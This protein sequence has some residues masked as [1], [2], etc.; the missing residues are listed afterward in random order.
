MKN[1]KI[2]GKIFFWILRIASL[3]IL[4]AALCIRVKQFLTR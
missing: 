2:T 1:R 3:I 4:L